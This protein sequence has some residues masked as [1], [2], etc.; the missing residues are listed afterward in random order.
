M[1]SREPLV[2][3]HPGI[4]EAPLHWIKIV[5]MCW[6]YVANVIPGLSRPARALLVLIGDDIAMT[7][8]MVSQDYNFE[9]IAEAGGIIVWTIVGIK[10]ILDYFRGGQLE[11]PEAAAG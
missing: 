9:D 3:A 1:L 2:A 8:W 5:R 4:A 11:D 10:R 6:V 7:F